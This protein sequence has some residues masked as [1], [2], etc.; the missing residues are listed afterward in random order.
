MSLLSNLKDKINYQLHQLT[1]DPEAEEYTASIKAA[2]EAEDAAKRAKDQKTQAEAKRK[3]DAETKKAEDAKKAEELAARKEFR[4]GRFAGKVVGIIST[5]LFGFAMVAGGIYGAHLATN[6]NL[7]RSWPYRLLYA[8][9]GFIFFPI[10]V[11]YM[12]GYRWWWQGKKP[13]YYA[14]LPLIPYFINQPIL[15]RLFSWMSYK[16]DDEIRALQ[17]WNQEISP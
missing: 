10:V 16:P 14:L 11:V 8:F 4:A 3:L 15:A 5:I 1:Y 17:E 13:Q 12:L 7:Y 9:Y 2:Q 6:A